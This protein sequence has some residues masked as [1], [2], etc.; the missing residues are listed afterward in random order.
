MRHLVGRALRVILIATV[1]A[2]IC[3]AQT[4]SSEANTLTHEARVLHF[5][6]DRSLGRLKIQDADIKRRIETFHHWVNGAGWG[7]FGEARGDVRVPAGKRIQLIVNKSAL[8]DLSPLAKLAPD[9][10]YALVLPGA[11]PGGLMA[12]DTCMPHVAYLT[13]LKELDL[14]GTHISSK[15]MKRI[16]KLTALERLTVPKAMGNGGLSYVSQLGSLKGLY[17][18]ENRVTN[19]G[20][21]HLAKLTL[22]EELDLG[23]ERMGDAGLVHLAKLPSL[24]YLMLWGPNWTDAGMAQLRNIPSLKILNLA[25]LPV[26]DEGLRRLAG[27]P[28]LENLSLYNTEITDGGLAYLKSMSSLKKL[29]I[30]TRKYDPENPPISDEGMV[31]VAELEGLEYL[32]LPNHGITDKGLA[33]ITKL[34]KLRHLWVCGSSN[35]PLTD[36]ALEHVSELRSL[37]YLLISGTGFTD[38]GMDDLAKLTNLREL[39]LCANSITNEGLAKLKTLKS[40]EKLSLRCEKVTISGL[41]HLNDLK[42]VSYLRVGGIKQDN[43]GLDIGGLSKLEKLGISLKRTKEGSDGLYD[44]D[45]ACLAKLR[46]LEW[47][48]VGASRHSMITDAGMAY[49][50]RLTRMDRLSIGSPYLTDEA[51]SYLTNMKPLDSLTIIGNFTDSGLSHLKGLKALTLLR[52]RSANNFSPAA[53]QRLRDNLP[54]LFTFTAEQD[55]EI[56]PGAVPSKTP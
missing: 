56:R 28:G 21:R 24:R 31:H 35:S 16:V 45:L 49:L 55:P 19:A 26:T 8:A 12:D 53:V 6:K 50:T 2:Q 40:L 42:N 7:H 22:L 18:K 37:E 5:P 46:N 36:I 39:N 13:G 11:F 41:S 10:L 33:Q 14:S 20:L 32:D 25:H 44:R 4:Q 27:H 48:Q 1:L 54:N 17:F 51:L 52:I 34:N 30:G 29:S 9:D 38:A 15:G 3:P 47:V 23:G 43:S